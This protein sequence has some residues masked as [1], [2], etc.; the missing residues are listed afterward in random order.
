VGRSTQPARRRGPRRDPRLA[1]R[2]RGI[3]SRLKLALFG[4]ST[5]DA[6]ASWERYAQAQ[7]A[8]HGARGLQVVPVAAM[9]RAIDALLA[10]IAPAPGQRLL[11]IGPGPHGGIGLVAALLGADVTFVEYDQPFVVDLDALRR[12]LSATPG[13]S[14]SLAQIGGLGGALKVDPIARLEQLLAPYLPLIEAAG[15]SV[16]IV[17][18][19]FAAPA[20][21]SQLHE[22]DAFDHVV[23]TD[24]VSPMGDTFS[25]TTAAFTTGDAERAREVL[26]G[27]GALS[28]AAATIYTA[29]IV[30]EESPEVGGRIAEWYSALETAFAAHGREQQYQRV[31][32]PSSGTV[33]RARLYRLS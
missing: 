4:I 7:L 15:G 2:I 16:E 11:D 21:R 18:G 13:T 24:V 6:C 19:D 29:F 31:V 27:L 17:P 25:T 22:L 33:V 30:P 3:V 9:P 26:E 20:L 10:S 12:Q 32:S 5:P 8:V 1:L 14:A 28:A 23:C